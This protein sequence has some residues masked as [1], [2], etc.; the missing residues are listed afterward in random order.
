MGRKS[1][2]K[3]LWALIL[4]MTMLFS[5]IP[6]GTILTF[7]SAELEVSQDIAAPTASKASGD[8]NKNVVSFLS[9]ATA[10]ATIYY[11]TDGTLPNMDSLLYDEYIMANGKAGREVTTTFNAIAVKEIDGKYYR[12]E[13][14]VFTYTVKLPSTVTLSWPDTIEVDGDAVEGNEKSWEV[15]YGETIE[16]LTFNAKDGYYFPE[17]YGSTTNGITISR[18]SES[19]IKVSGTPTGDV[20]VALAAPNEI[21][22]Q[23]STLYFGS[24]NRTMHYG[25]DPYTL[26]IAGGDGSGAVTYVS[27]NT[28][29]AE[30]EAT[31]GKITIKNVGKFKI[32]ATK[33]ASAGYTEASITSD[34]I[35]V[36]PKELII[37]GITVTGHVYDG[38][39]IVK[40]EGGK[41]TGV[42]TGDDV[43][44]VI[45][46]NVYVG[47]TEGL[48]IDANAGVD[49]PLSMMPTYTI[50]G[51]DVAK[52]ELKV[53]NPN[54]YKVTIEK[55][56]VDITGVLI[57]DKVYDGTTKAEV[58]FK[59]N[60]DVNDIL[61]ADVDK[62][63]I[64][65]VADSVVFDSANVNIVDNEVSTVTATAKTDGFVL[66]GS[67]A[68][69][70]QIGT[71]TVVPAKITPATLKVSVADVTR[72][73]G[74]ILKITEELE[75]T[76]S[77]LIGNDT[78]K[79][80]VATPKIEYVTSA[81]T[82][83]AIEV[84]YTGGDAGNNYIFDLSDTETTLNGVKVNVTTDDYTA[85]DGLKDWANEAIVV[86]PANGYNQIS[87]DGTNWLEKLTI[88]DDANSKITIYLKKADGTTTEAY[89][90]SYL[91]DKVK[92]EGVISIE[93]SYA[94]TAPATFMFFKNSVSVTITGTDEESKVDSIGYQIVDYTSTF[95]ENGQW[96][97]IENG[98]KFNISAKKKATIYAKIV[99]KAGN[100]TII[101]SD[102]VV[103]YTG[104][105]VSTSTDLEYRPG[106]QKE[107]YTKPV[108]TIT[109]D[110]N[111]IDKVVIIK[112]GV[113]I[114]VGYTLSTDGSTI[115]L[116]SADLDTIATTDRIQYTGK[117][118]YKAWGSDENNSHTDS[119][120][121][122]IYLKKLVTITD[123]MYTFD[124][125]SAGTK[126]YD[127]NT[128]ELA[129]TD[130][131][132]V[133]WEIIVTKKNSSGQYVE[134]TGIKDVGEYKV[135]L[136]AVENDVYAEYTSAEYTFTVTK[137]PVT[138]SGITATDRPYDGTV[139]VVLDSTNAKLDGMVENDDLSFKDVVSGTVTDANAGTGKEVTYV[140]SLT[141]TAAGNYEL[142]LGTVNVNITKV[143]LTLKVEDV[144]IYVGQSF[145]TLAITGITGLVG[146]ETIAVENYPTLDYTTPDV[147]AATKGELK[148]TFTGGNAGVNYQFP[149]DTT[150][151]Y[152]VEQWEED[153]YTSAEDWYDLYNN[154]VYVIHSEGREVSVDGGNTWYKQII[155]TTFA[156]DATSDIAA[157]EA[158]K[159]AWSDLTAPAIDSTALVHNTTGI[160][161][162][163]DVKIRETAE[164]AT[165]GATCVKTATVKLDG[166]ELEVS[167][168][169]PKTADG[170]VTFKSTID[171]NTYYFA[172]KEVFAEL[173]VNV[174]KSG[175]VQDSAYTIIT[176]DTVNGT[177]TIKVSLGTS[178]VVDGKTVTVKNNAGQT[179]TYDLVD[180]VIYSGEGSLKATYGTEDLNSS[181]KY[182]TVEGLKIVLTPG[183]KGSNDF[184]SISYKVNNGESQVALSNNT[185]VN[186]KEYEIN[187]DESVFMAGGTYSIVVT[188][189][190]FCGNEWEEEVT[191]QVKKEQAALTFAELTNVTYGDVVSIKDKVSGGSGNGTITYTSSDEKIATVD[192]SGNVTV[193]GMGSFTITATK[194]G[195]EDYREASVTSGT[196]TV[197]KRTLTIDGLDA[198]DR[199]YDGTTKVSL[200]G[201]TLKN[202]VSWDDAS[203][204]LTIPTEGTIGNANVGTK[205]VTVATIVIADE[206]ATKYELVQPTNIDVVISQKELTLSITP[207]EKEIDKGFYLNADDFTITAEG[208][209]GGDTAEGLTGFKVPTVAVDNIKHI[210]T[211]GTQTY[212]LTVN[213]DGNATDN[214]KFVTEKVT[215]IIAV[216]A[217]I[218][219]AGDYTLEGTLGTNGW[220]KSDVLI[221]PNSERYDIVSTDATYG[222][223][224]TSVTVTTE[225]EN[226]IV[227][228]FHNS[229]TGVIT[230][231]I[232]IPV[233]IDKKA[234]E[235]G[236]VTYENGVK[237][238]NLIFGKEIVT[239][240]V[241]V[242]DSTSGV[243]R[244]VYTKT[245]DGGNAENGTMA[246]TDGVAQMIIEPNFKGTVTAVVYDKAGNSYEKNLSVDGTGAG[247]IVEDNA[248]VIKMEVVPV[249]NN[250]SYEEL[251]SAKYYDKD[252]IDYLYMTVTD[253]ND[254]D[255]K[256]KE[257]TY[258]INDGNVVTVISESDYDSALATIR[259]QFVDIAQGTTVIKVTATDF[260]GNMV[261]ETFTVNVTQ[262][263]EPLQI[264]GYEATQTYGD[265]YQLDVTQQTAGS[266]GTGAI[267]Y[268]STN[269][270]VAT[271]DEAGNVTVVGVGTYTIKVTKAAST[272]WYSRTDET[273]T[274][275]VNK[276]PV[277]VEGLK[278]NNRPYDRTVYVTIVDGEVVGLINNDDVTFNVYGVGTMDDANV[279][280][281]KVVTIGEVTL[282]G[283]DA[284]KYVLSKQPTGLTVDITPVTLNV[285]VEKV[286][287]N[288]GQSIPTLTVKVTGFLDGDSE[289][290][291]G[292]VLPTATAYGT[293]DTMNTATTRFMVDYAG[294]DA[295]DNYQFSYAET[296]EIQI[297]T[298]EPVVVVDPTSDEYV[299]GNVKVLPGEG[300][301]LISTDEKNW[302]TSLLFDESGEHT[303]TVY[304]KKEDGSVSEGK[305]VSFKIDN[306]VPEFGTAKYPENIKVVAGY[307]IGKD[308]FDIS[309]PVSDEYSDIATVT[310][311]MG[312]TTGN[313][314]L[315]DGVAVITV[316]NGYKGDITIIATD[317]AGNETTKS[318][319]ADASASNGFIVEATAPVVNVTA[320]GA[321]LKDM[322]HCE[323]LEAVDVT[324]TDQGTVVS[325]LASVKYTVAGKETVVLSDVSSI[326]S[327]KTF[328]IPVAL[329]TTTIVITT[330]DNAGNEATKTVTIVI[331][332]VWDTESVEF[333]WADDYS[334]EA[335][336]T[337][338]HN[339]EHIMEDVC[340]VTS[341]VTDPT[342][343]E[344]GVTTY[345]A[346]VTFDGKKYTDVK[347]AP[348]AAIGHAYGK[349]VFTWSDDYKTV[350]VKFTCENDA[351]HVVT[352]ACE[353]TS[354]T[355]DP[356]CTVAGKTVYTATV[357]FENV[358]YTDVKE[359]VIEALGH[360]YGEPTYTWSADNS[361]AIA[362]FTCE[363]N[364]THVEKEICDVVSVT[365]DPTCEEAGKTVYTATVTFEDVE[366]T[367]TKTVAIEALGHAYGK[368]VFTWSDDY[369]T[370]S[371]K[372]TCANDKTHIVASECVVTTKTTAATCTEAGKIVYTAK[373]TLD[374]KDYTDVKEVVLEAIGHKY[375]EPVFTWAEDY[376]NAK[377][378]FTCEHDEKHVEEAAAVVTS[379]ITEATCT[380]D[381]LAV[382]TAKVTFEGKEYTDVR[383]VVLE[384]IG[385]KYGE[386]TFVWAEDYS[387]AEAT[388]T[389]EHD[390]THVV[391]KNCE[392]TNVV[393]KPTCEEAGKT[394]YTATV[395]FEGKEYTDV[396]EVAIEAIGHKYGE[397]EFAWSEDNKSA[398]ATFTCGNDKT[399]VKTVDCEV[400]E[401][402]TE[403]TCE[404]AGKTT[405][406]AAVTFEGKEYTDVKEV[407]I[408]A[409]GHKYGEATFVWA[410]D[411][412]SAKV[413][414]TCE[415]NETHVVDVNATV[416]REVIKE[417]IGSVKGEVLYTAVAE[418]EGETYTDTKTVVTSIIE[419]E[420][421]GDGSITVEVEVAD[422]V[423]KVSVDN[424]TIN[425]VKD[426]LTEEELEKV[427]AGEDIVVYL[428]VENI[429]D[430]V[431]AGDKDLVDTKMVSM[432]SELIKKFNYIAETVE[433]DMQYIDLSLFMQVDD[434][435]ATKLNGTGNNELVITIDI[436]ADMKSDNEKREYFAVRVH[437]G[438]EVE[439]LDSVCD[440]EAGTLTFKTDKFSTYAIAYIDTTDAKV[441]ES[442]DDKEEESSSNV[443]TPDKE[444][445]T[446]T[447]KPDDSDKDSIYTGDS[448]DVA[449]WMMLLAAA[450]GV[451]LLARRKRG[452]NASK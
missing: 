210:T 77:G 442:S 222:A 303:V 4:V 41:I 206:Y 10:G 118:Y 440:R 320:N 413:T 414:F 96:T 178:G 391:K 63:Q 350:S 396:K 295:T 165:K 190:D 341:V 262:D 395:A 354:V 293:V 46:E 316:P 72:N 26:I 451:T 145:P 267:T 200:K 297:N 105:T 175:I 159:A 405:Y 400:T 195:D 214:Y 192:A 394:T 197:L 18:V 90:L 280:T 298:V 217:V 59:G 31:T 329:G 390:K 246:I 256:L 219:T 81:V 332:H 30:V 441:N 366:Y 233:K 358:V 58:T 437:N 309:I 327:T 112:D 134:C 433:M 49:K 69:N 299:K 422:D 272:G 207:N 436:P 286:V 439:V 101:N 132:D 364:A 2:T 274:I 248:P 255:S 429:N 300:F 42:V 325:G 251:D 263:Q 106:S 47:K 356:T 196:I 236:T 305:T 93:K 213:S 296:A 52:Y 307:V 289:K 189:E 150:I 352:E 250:A 314:S 176:T 282:I 351:T 446:T 125:L 306:E 95:D 182:D 212:E 71:I 335:T 54:E 119:E 389:C 100:V 444:D 447:Q 39:N 43:T 346:A 55:K 294:G 68:G 6:E 273:A 141:G 57:A 392:V 211:L 240:R 108:V 143:K 153:L 167:K 384:A 8:Y 142:T 387:S 122:K 152:V 227:V 11:T 188:T 252:Y 34:E 430:S 194:A 184:K 73:N 424:L 234:P 151:N 89:E 66:A 355:T 301:T 61:A 1:K 144:K 146:S 317:N 48:L 33:A 156:A 62:L 37:E 149:A 371:A 157:S 415:H 367:T 343:E 50:T 128:V 281:G 22:P 88:D 7:A 264:S 174:G 290:M 98:G 226:T 378:V 333:T 328:S 12:S 131:I 79:L 427:E 326:E 448:T 377:V 23:A 450:F 201:G 410:E 330:V 53:P 171:G 208:F 416:T 324:V 365:T 137:K 202:Y 419:S 116:N 363:H 91:L 369:K 164:G 139:D 353:V 130:E 268:E 74:Y 126:V 277:T 115:T 35:T 16:T 334:C 229:K 17:G 254:I 379:D 70:Y 60:L 221:K 336:I 375:G 215:V 432:V 168:E 270:S 113:E 426:L 124:S 271:V 218:P 110:G 158:Y 9:T 183:L 117:V 406:T 191:L 258:T 370:A 13:E 138:L 452:V 45:S 114:Q 140:S 180:V 278:A 135:T 331:D 225:G 232:D 304:V 19:S 308:A 322:Y 94:L 319:S 173:V 238:S 417:A 25:D 170:E 177:A 275:T 381:G 257:I 259:K 242:S 199:V 340:D 321:A 412:S 65:D 399:H 104:I 21:V 85:A 403:S 163:L 312:T 288:K 269:E 434:N 193:K 243:D 380:V 123:T 291:T 169:T 155:Y 374:G 223:D 97:S 230:E 362:T 339:D 224:E 418:Y 397:A 338:K 360:A 179:M 408:E 423:P 287:I 86:E 205:D 409:L 67:A 136:H 284:D 231:T 443:Q 235:F 14:A 342:C 311:A 203:K 382:Y 285:S 127:G 302:V 228:S 121:F 237:F 393:T 120:E 411:Y 260:A 198:T 344:D 449:M 3:R 253:S 261:T 421:V 292:F 245:P 241:P 239:I 315:V 102:G 84:I 345:T 361:M 80:P 313:V 162:T 64:A 323:E 92:P 402:V 87:T 337:C 28:D 265:S 385:H 431:P 76:C 276:K 75:V 129:V 388:F 147:S 186:N 187:I 438:Q 32:I 435:E 15:A 82:S 216:N 368:P 425:L 318:L 181:K 56:T 247:F 348:I 78:V 36:E 220:Y 44:L 154:K 109:N 148:V 373:V 376:S 24:Y 249:D 401:V 398:T 204:I 445:E 83:Q 38:S 160:D 111:T 372:I 283:A 103:V 310:Y 404:E 5:I 161:T 359:V 27:T 99:D 133:T 383:E 420:P 349:P 279:G 172:N 20:E 209:V 29:V 166:V 386:A 107:Q 244:V 51:D 428:Q 347:T 40:V 357:T 185:V 266:N 407:A